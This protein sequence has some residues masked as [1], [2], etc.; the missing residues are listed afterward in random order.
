MRIILFLFAY[1]ITFPSGFAQVLISGHVVSAFSGEALPYVNIGIPGTE[2]GTISNEDGSFSIRI[3]EGL[4]NETI[5]FS[6]IG[7]RPKMYS[8]S[9][10]SQNPVL[11]VQLQKRVVDL[12]EIEVVG[13]QSK[14]RRKT[15]GNGSSLLLSGQLHFD[16]AYAGGGMA[17]LI[18]RTGYPEFS[19]LE[20]AS[21][22][23]AK[24]LS[25]TFKVRLRVMGVDSLTG[26]PKGDLLPED[27]IV[28][29]SIR[30]GWLRFRPNSPLK[31]KDSSFFLVF[32]WILT[33]NDRKEITKAYS[34]YME[35]FPERVFYDSIAVKG[36]YVLIP[37]INKVVSGTVFGVTG[38][39]KDLKKH[40]SY[41]RSNSFG[42]WKKSTGILSAK[43]SM[44]TFPEVKREREHVA[45]CNSKACYFDQWLEKFR[46]NY[47]VVGAQLSIQHNDTL[48]YSGVSGISDVAKGQKVKASTQFRIASISKSMTAAAIMLLHQRGLVDL[49]LP[50]QTYVPEF[51]L[52]QHPVS[53][54]QLLSHL[55]GIKDFDEKTW[56]EIF[57]QKHYNSLTDALELFENEPLVGAPGSQF[58]YSSYGYILLGA[59]IEQVTK[60]SYQEFMFQNFWRPLKMNST[61]CEI[62]DSIF[63]YKSKFYF[64]NGEESTP[65]NLSYSYSSGGLLSTTQ[66]LVRF[67]LAVQNNMVLKPNVK[68]DMVRNQHANDGKKTGYGLGWYIGKDSCQNQ[69]YYHA[70]ELP[71]SG[72]L[73]MVFP[74]EGIS[75]ALLTNSPILLETERELMLELEALKGKIVKCKPSLLE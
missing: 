18:D 69:I 30:R 36:E 21:L 57:I 5:H 74:S 32:E 16:S 42:D 39:K 2:F 27:L 24:N 49:N 53:V 13:H 62:A 14:N 58:N 63:L 25:S 47:G 17:L 70:G 59:I 48:V 35:T 31:V 34:E 33:E 68:A 29:S 46:S 11:T 61:A 43:V 72:S 20:E 38:S 9:M 28:H 7:F 50:I 45:P 15:F 55:G 64:L 23:I 56:D 67:G 52:K 54:Q 71:S 1:L 40:S 37:Q 6:S 3:P 51:P 65:Y 75:I 10:L 4:Q 19:F 26:K 22:Y 41:F 12:R 8:V 66:D 60:Q 44:C 73:L